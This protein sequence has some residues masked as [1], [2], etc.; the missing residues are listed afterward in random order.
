MIEESARYRV[1]GRETVELALRAIIAHRC[2]LPG[3]ARDLF[4]QLHDE[5]SERTGADSDD[6]A[7]WDFTGIARCHSVLLDKAEPTTA[8]EAFRRARPE[9]AERTPG[10][11]DRLRFMVETLADGD[12]RLERVLT[13]LARIRPGRIG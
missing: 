12:P 7:A 5:T 3:T 1:A 10:L 13:E 4:Q 2:R 6:L 9:P 8:L 11:D